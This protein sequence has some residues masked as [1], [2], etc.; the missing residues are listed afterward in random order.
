MAASR[1]RHIRNFGARLR[2]M[3]QAP[4]FSPPNLSPTSLLSIIQTSILTKVM[5]GMKTS[6]ARAFMRRED[7]QPRQPP[8][9]SPF[10][11]FDDRRL[12]EDYECKTEH[13]EA[14]T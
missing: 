4:A 12:A 7:Y 6:S 11:R 10:R 14:A 3:E 2:F 1:R 5:N 9:D 8:K 13:S